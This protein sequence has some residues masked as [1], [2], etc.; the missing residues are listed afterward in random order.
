M[1]LPYK[2]F[3]IIAYGWDKIETEGV[4]ACINF[5]KDGNI[6]LFIHRV[7][8]TPVTCYHQSLSSQTKERL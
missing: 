8:I 4:I 6:N 1:L 2:M 7:C 5:T 3:L